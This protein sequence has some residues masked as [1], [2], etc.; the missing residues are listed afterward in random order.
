MLVKWNTK[1]YEKYKDV[2]EIVV[3]G[4]I[5]FMNCGENWETIKEDGYFLDMKGYSVEGEFVKVPSRSAKFPM[6]NLYMDIPDELGDMFPDLEP[7]FHYDYNYTV[8]YI[9][10]HTGKWGL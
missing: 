8:T 6:S 3:Y 2:F 9:T 5:C 7:T 10:S 1:F 4:R